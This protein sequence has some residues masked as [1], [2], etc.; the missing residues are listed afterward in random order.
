V[1]RL[2]YSDRYLL[3]P[4]TLQL[5]AE[6][7]RSTPGTAQAT[8]DIQLAQ[9][10]KPPAD[11]RFL[12]HNFPS[13]GMRKEVLQA[14]L[15]KAMVVLRPKHDLQ[16]HRSLVAELADGR[17][18]TVILDKGFGSWRVEGSIRHDFGRTALQQ[19]SAI[20]AGA[21]TLRSDTDQGAPLAVKME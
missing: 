20:A 6:L 10:D 13:D 14:L 21:V 5:L 12:H 2:A 18:F 7:L 3:S 1:S 16:H 19:A 11:P 8:M 9:D 17:V 4:F 15:P